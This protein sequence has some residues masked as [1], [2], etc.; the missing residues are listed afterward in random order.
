MIEKLSLEPPA[1][2]RSAGVALL[3]LGIVLT[4]PSLVSVRTR[5][6]NLSI[7]SI[8]A[9]L[10]CAL[11]VSCLGISKLISQPSTVGLSYRRKLLCR[12]AHRIRVLCF[13]L[14]LFSLFVFPSVAELL[15]LTSS[16]RH[17]IGHG[18]VPAAGAR[19]LPVP[20]SSA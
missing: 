4:L 2:Q 1:S 11:L 12:Y 15:V 10:L 20:A 9:V 5:T 6:A 17:G 7:Y 14:A 13:V 16:W 18:F 3:V 19:L 8:E